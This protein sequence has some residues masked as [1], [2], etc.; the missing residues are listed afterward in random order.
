V[1][2]GRAAGPPAVGILG[3][4]AMRGSG[5]EE[6]AMSRRERVV[7]GVD[8]STGSRDAL[9]FALEEA[10]RRDVDLTVVAVVIALPHWPEAYMVAGPSF[11][12]EREAGMRT[13]VRRMVD[14]VLAARP[15]L[16]AA[17]VHLHVVGGLPAEVLIE[18]S[19]GA[20]LLVVGHRGRGGLA[21][22]VL[23]SVG[24]QCVLHAEC[25]V[26]VVRPAVPQQPTEK[27][28]PVAERSG[29]SGPG[30]AFVGPLY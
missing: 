2:F 11:T 6:A 30:S 23:G 1:T 5:P 29:R 13:A 8:G 17:R 12:E 28:E 24:L 10:V 20:D 4:V 18:Q 25:P 9:L 14:D 15:A 3:Q 16:A 7:V 19:R 26:V 27:A 22:A 21:S